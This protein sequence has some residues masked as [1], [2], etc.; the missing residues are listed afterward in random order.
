MSIRQ[1]QEWRAYADLEPFDEKRADYRAAQ[2]EAAVLNSAVL[3]ATSRGRGKPKFGTVKL[4]DCLLRF[5]SRG[6][7]GRTVE[8]RREEIRK[9]MGIL[10]AIFNDPKKGKG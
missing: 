8:E 2:V 10:M 9:T 6:G 7:K 5:E 4:G 3:I 1:F